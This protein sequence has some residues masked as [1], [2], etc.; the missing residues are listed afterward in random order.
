MDKD[1]FENKAMQTVAQR[2]IYLQQTEEE[3]KMVIKYIKDNKLDIS[4]I[5]ERVPEAHELRC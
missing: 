2:N 4:A 3:R 1:G 5:D